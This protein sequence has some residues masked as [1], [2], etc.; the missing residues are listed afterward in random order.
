RGG[1]D[2]HPDRHEPP[3]PP[4]EPG[5]LGDGH[6]RGQRHRHRQRHRTDEGGSHDDR[7]PHQSQA[8]VRPAGVTR[9]RAG[10]P[11]ETGGSTAT[12]SAAVT[13]A[14]RSAGSPFSQTRL[15]ASTAAK[16]SPNRT[17][18][19]S[20]TSPTVAS[21]MTSRPVP[22]ASRAAANSRRT[23]TTNPAQASTSARPLAMTWSPLLWASK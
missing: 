22:A 12:S 1:Q 8:D 13:A 18:A 6:R 3:G 21:S 4:M 14:P 7:R 16:P 2:Q 17:A 5:D 11:P 10:Q 20:S 19:A 15:P 9:D 23:A